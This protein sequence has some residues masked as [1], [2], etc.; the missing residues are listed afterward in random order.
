MMMARG[1]T[2]WV[3]ALGGAVAGVVVVVL[4]LLSLAAWR[5]GEE[6]RGA[7]ATPGAEETP[8]ALATA[9]AETT[10]LPA[11]PLSSTPE[12]FPEAGYAVRGRTVT[13]TRGGYQLTLPTGYRVAER[14][15]AQEASYPANL[16]S[17][18][19]TK[20]TEAQEEE[21]VGLLKKL[22]DEQVVTDAPQ[23]LPG[24]TI[25]IL[26]R[27]TDVEEKG[28]AQLAHSKKDLTTAAG[29]PATR[30]ER[31]EGPFTYD[32]T[33]VTLPGGKKFAIFMSYSSGAP[34]FD[35]AAYDAVIGSLAPL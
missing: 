16:A 5:G 24:Q 15:V 11:L 34:A 4:V 33:Y 13:V 30:Y 21:Y 25:T 20:G 14:L 32:A 26:P 18:K 1:S 31:V 19:I 22:A 12:G 28:D 23:F 29:F 3:S 17:F 9:P 7:R 6:E 27:E 35:E 2:L 10:P 8:D